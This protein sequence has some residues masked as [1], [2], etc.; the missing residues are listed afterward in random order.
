M[1]FTLIS[2]NSL[3]PVLMYKENLEKCLSVIK[4]LYL[5]SLGH[6]KGLTLFDMEWGS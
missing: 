6:S 5:T 4:M 3:T 2:V 1:A